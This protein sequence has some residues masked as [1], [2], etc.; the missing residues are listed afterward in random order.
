MPFSPSKKE[1]KQFK[2][3]P[4]CSIEYDL[5]PCLVLPESFK[6]ALSTMLDVSLLKN[7]VF[8]IICISNMFGMAGLYIPFAYLVDAAKLGVSGPKR[9]EFVVHFTDFAYHS[10]PP[11]SVPHRVFQKNRHHLYF[12]L[13]ASQTHLVV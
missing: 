7:P 11:S 12:Q 4:H 2:L 6:S 5:C 3:I 8:I 9:F 13:S 1:T 10:V